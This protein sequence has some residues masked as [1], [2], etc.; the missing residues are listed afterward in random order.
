MKSVGIFEAKTHLS[1][2]VEAAGPGEEIVI[3]VRGTP[4]ARLVPIG[5]TPQGADAISRLLASTERMGMPIREAIDQ[6]RRF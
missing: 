2:L 4:T 1:A 5:G 3:S 6:G